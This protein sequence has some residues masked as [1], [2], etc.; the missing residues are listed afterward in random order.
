MDPQYATGAVLTLVAAFAL[1]IVGFA[2]GRNRAASPGPS[3]GL[4][5]PINLEGVLLG[6]GLIALV[7][8]LVLIVAAYSEVHAVHEVPVP[9]H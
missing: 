2:L 9:T 5:P 3:A 6:L 1:L 8:G 4:G 7:L